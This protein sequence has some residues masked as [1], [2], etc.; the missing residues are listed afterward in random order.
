MKYIALLRGINVGGHKKFP[1]A[2]QLQML[3][4][5]GC[6]DAQVYLHTGNWI[7][8][9]EEEVAAISKTISAAIHKKKDWE[10]P[11]LVFTA[12]EFERIFSACP[13]SEDIKEKSYFTLLDENPTSERVA[14]LKEYTYP[15][16]EYRIKNKCVYFYP[17]M[18]A[19]K[20]KM[21]NNFFENKLKVTATSR[22]YRTMA[23]LVAMAAKK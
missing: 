20:S 23:K 19:G 21:S 10:V 8:S 3:Q 6:K 11:V 2:E 22:N 13:F 1:K 15:R 16:E 17:A 9:S 18:G 4:N 12:L 7:F 5:L 14:I